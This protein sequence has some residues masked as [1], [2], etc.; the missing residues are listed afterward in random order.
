[1]PSTSRLKIKGPKQNGLKVCYSN[2]FYVTNGQTFPS[3]NVSIRLSPKIL[4]EMEKS[5]EAKEPVLVQENKKAYLSPPSPPNS[6]QKD[7]NS[8]SITK[9][10]NSATPTP[11]GSVDYDK[12]LKKRSDSKSFHNGDNIHI[13]TDLVHDAKPKPEETTDKEAL[14]N[15]ASSND[16]ST[17][18]SE[19]ASFNKELDQALLTDDTT[20]S[21]EL[22]DE[23]QKLPENSNASADEDIIVVD[24]DSDYEAKEPEKSESESE[25]ESEPQL[26]SSSQ[27]RIKNKLPEL[28][29]D[30][31]DVIVDPITPLPP[32]DLS[33]LDKVSFGN[34][35]RT[36]LAGKSNEGKL[37]PGIPSTLPQ[38]KRNELTQELKEQGYRKIP[39]TYATVMRRELSLFTDLNSE[40]DMIEKVIFSLKDPYSG[41]KVKLPIKATSCK[42]FECF[43]FESF[44]KINIG[45][46]SFNQRY[47]LK[48]ELINKNH[49]ARRLERLFQEQ[50]KKQT[51]NQL[52]RIQIAQKGKIPIYTYPQYSEHGQIFHFALYHKTPPLFKCPICDEL[53]GIKQ[54]YISDVFN[55]FVKGTPK[56][57]DR[58]ELLDMDCYR[59]I[60]GEGSSNK[61]AKEEFI[62]L[63]D[64]DLDDE[65][66]TKKAK[67][68][69]KSESADDFNDGLDSM[70]LKLNDKDS[71]RG[72]WDDPVTLD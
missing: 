55:Y 12:L 9:K 38:P 17:S 52:P 71:G 60:D 64:E 16:R 66:L 6:Q 40:E 11:L 53:F 33:F 4:N 63:T 56:D 20:F 28:S 49:E 61:K 13:E 1:M 30:E 62:E 68:E 44:C 69:P 31:D 57:V 8:I 14:N 18:E 39:L 23:K 25:S 50:H 65:P 35:T 34:R 26:A 10:S 21:P 46:I 67:V 15:T 37:F 45:K 19:L 48:Q 7:Q 59:I 5:S 47:H 2:D 72:S 43:D 36:Q 51:G 22:Q 58:I 32:Q 54:L 70:F 27:P 41:A 29:D 24:S 3:F 42:H